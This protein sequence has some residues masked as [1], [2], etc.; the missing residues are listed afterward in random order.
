PSVVTADHQEATIKIAQEVPFITGQYTNGTNAAFGQVTPFET[1]QREEVGTILKITPQINEGDS[2][3]LKIEMESSSVV[4]KNA[5]PQGAV[6]LTTNKRTVSTNV[7]IEDGG[8][9]VIGGLISNEYDRNNTGVPFLSSIPL[10]G[11]LFKDR[12]GTL[13]K[14]DLMIFIRPQILHDGL[15]TQLTTN[16]KYNFMRDLQRQVGSRELLPLV[17]GAKTILPPLP[18]AKPRD[19][20]RAKPD[21]APDGAAKPDA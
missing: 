8:I 2:V 7:L 6:D 14:K 19:E 3:I 1:V 12:Q 4:P 16:A 21:A 10:L 13:Q 9:I 20:K 17:P 15:D 18:P 11:Q 5:G